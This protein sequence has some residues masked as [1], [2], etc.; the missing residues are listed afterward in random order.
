MGV[1]INFFFLLVSFGLLMIFV[2]FKPLD[3]KKKEF[4]DIPLFEV[5]DFSVYELNAKGLN[6]FII[7]DNGVR[8][9]NRYEFSN[10]N[11][12][13]KTKLYIS[14]MKAKKGLYIGDTVEFSGGV[15]YTRDD[16]LS[17]KTHKARY[18]RRS[19]VASTEDKYIAYIGNNKITGISFVYN[20]V[21]KKF[22]SKDIRA[23]YQIKEE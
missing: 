23:I 7:A 1:N 6:D 20:T 22:V 9:R 16:G 5:K 18:N 12:I 11:Y 21:L 13:D 3:V 17:F 10:I 14:N 8:Y 4:I 2:F 19:K 15:S